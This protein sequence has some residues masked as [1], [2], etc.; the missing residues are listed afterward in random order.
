MTE[1][2]ALALLVV[3]LREAN[4]W[5]RVLAAPVLR[6]RIE[7]TLTSPKERLVYQAST[8]GSVRDVEEATGVSKSSVQNYWGRW[9]AAGIMRPSAAAGRYERLVDLRSVGI[10]V[11]RGGDS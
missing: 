7:N 1:T 6:E 11:G 5:L 3:E 4:L 8:G 9:A 10:E 2:E